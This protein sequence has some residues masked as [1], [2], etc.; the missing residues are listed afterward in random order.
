MPISHKIPDP[1]H[2]HVTVP[3]WLREIESYPSVRRMLYIR[4][5]GLK[6]SIDFPGAIHTRYGHSLGAMHLAG[7]LVDRLAERMHDEGNSKIEEN[8]K[9]N[10]NNLM[11]AGLLHD[12]AHGPFSHAIDF[13]LYQTANTSHEELTKDVIN[14]DLKGALTNHGIIPE[15]VINIINKKHD[16]KFISGIVNGPM[17]VDKLDYLL[18]DAHHVGLRYSFDLDHFISSYTVLGNDSELSKCKLGLDNTPSTQVTAEIFVMIWKGMYDLVYH[19]RDSRI[20]EKMLEKATMLDVQNDGEIKNCFTDKKLLL[21][22]DDER[23]LTLLKESKIKYVRSLEDRIR[24]RKLF[25]SLPDIPLY[26]NSSIDSNFILKIAAASSKE[27][28]EISDRMSKEVCKKAGVEEY[29]II[30]DIVKTRVPGSI[31]IAEISGGQ[32]EPDE[33][34]NRS[35]IIKNIRERNTMRIYFDHESVL[36][37]PKD[38]LTIITDIMKIGGGN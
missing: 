19:V 17:D 16:F 7:V 10:K 26:D 30:C 1:I 37:A 25:E 8:L 27:T 23:L 15:A 33:L 34:R 2:G 31:F 12:I 18:R 22:L 20:A 28:N 21:T 29:N 35:D 9:N 38:L 4:Q 14:S 36:K 32:G 11:A 6:S 24:N 13:V 3:D 5:L